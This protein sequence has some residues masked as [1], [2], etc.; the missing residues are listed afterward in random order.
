MGPIEQSLNVA[1]LCSTPPASNAAVRR[2]FDSG[3]RLANP[4]TKRFNGI[5]LDPDV[6]TAQ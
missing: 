5:E 2:P 6:L 4:D 1:F 3:Q